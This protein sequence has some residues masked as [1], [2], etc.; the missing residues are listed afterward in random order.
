ML[1]CSVDVKYGNETKSVRCGNIKVN[2]KCCYLVSKSESSL[3]EVLLL[4][5]SEVVLKCLSKGMMFTPCQNE[6]CPK[7]HKYTV[8]NVQD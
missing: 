7:F 2:L 6:L 1:K 3:L 5:P 8:M 4:F